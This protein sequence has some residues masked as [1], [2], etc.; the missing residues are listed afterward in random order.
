[1]NIQPIVE[2]HGE[3]PAVPILLRR[4]RDMCGA[5]GI[6]INR[7][8]RATRSQLV[9][10]DTLKQRVDLALLQENCGAILIIFDADDDCPLE[11]APVIHDWAN[12]QSGPVP[13]AI[14]MA[15][16]EYEAWF[17]ASIESL[18]GR[19]NIRND[20]VSHPSPEVPRAA[21]GQLEDRMVEGT[22]YSE[23][24]DQPALTALF[25]MNQAYAQC[26]SFRHLVTAFGS[27]VTALGHQL[28]DWPPDD[29]RQEV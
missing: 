24:V 11:L 27:Q 15:N 21:K 5:F 6:D 20:A 12:E 10:E 29:W 25:E 2:G 23:T 7:P 26:R 9:R 8:I 1:M 13:S 4:L 17:L 22:S 16:R 3:V 19:R 18:R 14:V 28:I